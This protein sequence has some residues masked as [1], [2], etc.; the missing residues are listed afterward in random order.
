MW[1]SSVNVYKDVEH[2]ISEF[3]GMVR[4]SEID[5][6]FQGE[7]NNFFKKV[8]VGG[9]VVE[10][11]AGMHHKKDEVE[12]IIGIDNGIDTIKITMGM[13]DAMNLK[14][15]D[16]IKAEIRSY[17]DEDKNLCKGVYKASSVEVLGHYEIVDVDQEDEEEEEE[18][19]V[20][21]EIKKVKVEK[22]SGD[23]QKVSDENK[24][25]VEETESEKTK[26]DVD[27]FN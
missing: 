27:L 17:W 14:C 15:G 21:K 25:I 22:V 1:Y 26:M 2:M 23:T 9:M 19:V 5:G 3:E 13:S 16:Y 4:F 12:G 11:S 7:E 20:K 8:L 6:N 24:S 10:W 18:L